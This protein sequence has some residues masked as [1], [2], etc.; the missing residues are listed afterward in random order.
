MDEEIRQIARDISGICP[1]CKPEDGQCIW[2]EPRCYELGLYFG[3][4]KMYEKLKEKNLIK[5]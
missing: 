1:E 5:E 2:Y 4:K 3:A